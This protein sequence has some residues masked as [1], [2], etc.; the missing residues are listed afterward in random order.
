MTT[1]RIVQ[2]NY[3]IMIK[4][5]IPEWNRI[6]DMKRTNYNKEYCFVKSFGIIAFSQT[7]CLLLFYLHLKT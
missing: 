5:K 3:W 6:K 4:L 1:S 7:E 2:R